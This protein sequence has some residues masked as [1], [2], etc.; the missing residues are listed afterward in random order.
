MKIGILTYHRSHNYGAVLQ[1]FALKKFLLQNG[2]IDVKFID[3]FPD[4]HKSM[5]SNIKPKKFADLS[6]K[7]KIMYYKYLIKYFLPEYISQQRRINSFNRFIKKKI[8][9]KNPGSCDSEY[10]IIIYGSDQIWRKE[11]KATPQGFKKI[12]FGSVPLK[13]KKK[14]AFSASMGII[15]LN[16]DDKEFLKIALKNFNAI[17]V[18]EI[19][20]KNELKKISDL[21][22]EHTVDPVLLLKDSW[23]LYTKKIN[24]RKEYI[25][26]YNLFNDD[27]LNEIAKQVSEKYSYELVYLTGKIDRIN[28]NKKVKYNVNPL[29]FITLISNS[30]FVITSSY[31]GVL[32][33]IIFEKQF[34]CYLDWN[35]DRV[36]SV[37]NLLGLSERFVTNDPVLNLKDKIDYKRVNK[38]LEKE[39]LKSKN[40]ILKNCQIN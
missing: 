40:F 7:G 17:S 35:I 16:N 32:F 23:L 38:I 14:I 26:V 30:K 29:E 11:K 31:H 36:K 6:L 10:D 15:E 5:Y 2:F 4:F 28:R 12:Y 37:L 9:S 21:P 24:Y 25:L 3:Y 34:Y 19:Q 8:I 27:I 18:R 39:I 13:A 22:I 33:S 20:L 1:A